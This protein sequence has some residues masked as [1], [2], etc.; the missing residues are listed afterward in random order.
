M[1]IHQLLQSSGMTPEE[2]SC[3]TKAYE[4]ALRK[5]GSPLS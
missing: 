3:V 4:Q 5:L 2:I 1:G